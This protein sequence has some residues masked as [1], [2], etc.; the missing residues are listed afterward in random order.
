MGF[1]SPAL[2]LL[3]EQPP[4]QPAGVA[5]ARGGTVGAGGG[6]LVHKGLLG[7]READAHDESGALVFGLGG[8]GH[9]GTLPGQMSVVHN[10]FYT[11]FQE[12]QEQRERPDEPV[13]R[14]GDDPGRSDRQGDRDDKGAD[15]ELFVSAPG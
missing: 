4:Q 5:P 13:T 9:E 14:A 11:N 1:Q 6:E 10:A 15:L 3:V 8:A 7:G 2:G 12:K